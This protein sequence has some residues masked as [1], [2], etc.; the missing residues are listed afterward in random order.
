MS[1]QE[2]IVY[3]CP[4]GELN[5]KI[6]AYFRK[7]RDVC[8]ANLAH[9]YMPHCS[10]TGFFQDSEMEIFPH[11][12]ILDLLLKL[13]EISIKITGMTFKENWHGLEIQAPEL[14]QLI[15]NFISE[16]RAIANPKNLRSKEWLHLSFA[17]NFEAE[18]HDK[19]KQIALDLI[20][21]NAPVQW[22]IRFYQRHEDGSWR[23][24]QSWQV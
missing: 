22:E 9:N 2:L 18:N 4:V 24:H 1:D 14:K 17:Y 8:G 3:A 19:L 5:D 13:S 12:K 21:I 16:S 6:E 20:D 11:I 23:C 7:S 15:A 10:L